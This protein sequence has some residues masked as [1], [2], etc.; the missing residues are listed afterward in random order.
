MEKLTVTHAKTHF[1]RYV[2]DVAHYDD[3]LKIQNQRTLDTVIV[4]SERTWN[5]QCHPAQNAA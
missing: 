1:N 4:V 5:A 2:R 3:I